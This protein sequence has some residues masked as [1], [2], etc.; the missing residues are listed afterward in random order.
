LRVAIA[1]GW[2]TRAVVTTE[3]KEVKKTSRKVGAIKD[4]LLN[5]RRS[6]SGL[7]S[8]FLEKVLSSLEDFRL[9]G[10]TVL[11]FDDKVMES[12]EKMLPIRNDFIDFSFMLFKYRDS[13]DLDQI[14]EFFEKLVAL[15]FR[16]ENVQSWAEI[17]YDNFRFFNYELVLSFFAVL[18]RLKKYGELGFFFHS[19]Y[20][21]RNSSGSLE[22]RGIEILNQF[23]E[24]LDTFRNNRLSLQR[25]S[26]TADLIKARATRKD[27]T[28]GDLRT[29][30]LVLHYVTSLRGGG[31]AWFPRTS[32][33][34]S[35]I[36]GIELFDRMVSARHF[37]K[38]KVL[39]GVGTVAELK[40]LIDVYVRNRDA[41]RYSTASMWNFQIGR[42][43]NMIK[44]EEIA[45]TA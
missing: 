8:D 33:Y 39:F 11:G 29:T 18:L 37:E 5:E 12:V 9:A 23:V 24:S 15:T 25:A 43:E 13:V 16:P 19:A 10:G 36:A 27:V 44:P 42:V 40:T 21:Y 26:V 20:F 30:D 2:A 7:I 1:E 38:V 31:F 45:T 35:R 28:F 3:R 6:A 17:D 4:A 41:N 32:V 34:G 22:Q 14:H